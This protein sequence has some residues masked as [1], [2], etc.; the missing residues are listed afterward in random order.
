MKLGD[1]VR[2]VRVPATVRD[3]VEFPSRTLFAQ[4]V[5]RVFPIAGFQR[6]DGLPADLIELEVGEVLGK[7]AYEETIWVEPDCV[8]VVEALD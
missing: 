1:Q 2:L 8:E 6:V 5:G 4:C 7:A 3:D